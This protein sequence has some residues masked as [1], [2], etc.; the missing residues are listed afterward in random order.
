MRGDDPH[1][2]MPGDPIYPHYAPLWPEALLT[3]A[4][5]IAQG[6]AFADQCSEARKK[7]IRDT[8]AKF[9][10]PMP[11]VVGRKKRRRPKAETLR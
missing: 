11:V 1:A 7:V 6:I 10:P 4:V 8:I 9:D 5:D 3:R 2:I